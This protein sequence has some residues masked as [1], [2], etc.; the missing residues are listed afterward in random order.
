MVKYLSKFVNDTSNLNC[1]QVNNPGYV[2]KNLYFAARLRSTKADN[3]G[4]EI[5]FFAPPTLAGQNSHAQGRR[6]KAEKANI[7][8]FC[9]KGMEYIGCQVGSRYKIPAV[10][11]LRPSAAKKYFMF[12]DIINGRISFSQGMRLFLRFV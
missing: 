2:S 6:V 7:Y 9:P 3:C 11:C 4:Q 8:Y 10:F 5:M 12:F 1:M